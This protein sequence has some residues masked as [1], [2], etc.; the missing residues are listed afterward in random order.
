MNAQLLQ[1]RLVVGACCSLAQKTAKRS[2]AETPQLG[3]EVEASFTFSY[4]S[5]G[6][7]LTGGLQE[8]WTLG[9]S[10]TSRTG[11][12]PR[13]WESAV[14]FLGS[15]SLDCWNPSCFVYVFASPERSRADDTTNSEDTLPDAQNTAFPSRA[16]PPLSPFSPSSQ[17]KI[18]VGRARLASASKLLV[19]LAAFAIFATLPGTRITW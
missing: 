7:A 9:D 18:E 13:G 16:F 19:T 12:V 15:L 3:G 6:F 5:S 8:T 2:H 17:D 1:T 10:G 14:R 4:R 11:K